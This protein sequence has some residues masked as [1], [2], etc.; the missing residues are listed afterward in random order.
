MFQDIQP[1]HLQNQNDQQR[2]P[3]AGDYVLIGRQ[4]AVVLTA[5]SELPTY[6]MTQTD[7]SFTADQYVYLLAVDKT[8]FYW[9][10]VDAQAQ[11]T[12]AYQVGATR[13]FRRMTPSWLAFSSATAAHLAWWYDTNR[14]CGHCGQP[15]RRGTTER[16]LVCDACGQ[17]SYPT[18]MPA[19]IVGVTHGDKLLLTKFLAGYNH[20]SL[21]SG[22]T[23]IGESFEDTVRREVFEEVGLQVHN[24]KYFGSQPWA[25]S[26][27]LLAG[28]FAE[29]D[30]DI[31]ID[32]ETDELAKAQW[33]HRDDLPHNAEDG[34]MSLTW[35]MIEA[36]R[37]SKN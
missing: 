17:T 2:P 18:I 6:E 16:S 15:L 13:D 19:I 10:D 36:F 22:Y 23:E 1:H 9:V 14:F 29:L 7:W 33:F 37:H 26:H 5:A 24:L 28:Y 25:P 20:Y 34:T 11:A 30:K 12:D 32:L 31:V 3:R 4:G 8:A 27:S 35:T 21:I